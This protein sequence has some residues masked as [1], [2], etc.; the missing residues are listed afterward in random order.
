MIDLSSRAAVESQAPK[1]TF[2]QA[3]TA[4]LSIANRF[5]VHIAKAVLT[6]IGEDKLSSESPNWMFAEVV[7]LSKLETSSAD[8]FCAEWTA[9]SVE[10]LEKL[11]P[12]GPWVLAAIV[13]DGTPTTITAKTSKEAQ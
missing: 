7:R 5:G 1:Y 12:G 6:S 2:E 13:P 9:E 8:E 3:K 4:L 11:R 10:F